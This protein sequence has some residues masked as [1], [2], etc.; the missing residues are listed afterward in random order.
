MGKQIKQEAGK[1][2]S[3]VEMT[4]TATLNNFN[5]ELQVRS[6]RSRPGFFYGLVF[7][8]DT[9]ILKRQCSAHLRTLHGVQ[10]TTVSVLNKRLFYVLLG[11]NA[12]LVPAGIMKEAGIG[13]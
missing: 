2:S 12:A 3:N 8:S 1:K 9:S 10:G 13:V 4:H 7:V 6:G 5:N 11:L